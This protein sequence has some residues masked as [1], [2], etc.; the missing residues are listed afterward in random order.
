MPPI[1]HVL[2]AAHNVMLPARNWNVPAFRFYEKA[3]RGMGASPIHSIRQRAALNFS[4][5]IGHQM[6]NYLLQ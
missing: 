2:L 6:Y 3:R 5:I 4:L 1:N